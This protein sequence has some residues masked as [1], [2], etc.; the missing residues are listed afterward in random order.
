MPHLRLVVDEPETDPPA[1][2]PIRDWR[3]PETDDAVD[4]IAEV[5]K[6]LGRVQR[7]FDALN[8][9][10]DELDPLPFPRRRDPEDDGPWAA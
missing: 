1:P 4:S 2:L 5:E 7:A 10:M 6:A 9:Q 8:D 3:R